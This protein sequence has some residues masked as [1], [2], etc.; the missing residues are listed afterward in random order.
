MKMLDAFSVPVGWMPIWR[1]DS[2]C[3]NFRFSKCGN[4]VVLLFFD[5]FV[6]VLLF[7]GLSTGCLDAE[8]VVF[9]A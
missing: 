2:G 3:S 6:V 8:E 1:P 9:D 7:I 5:R 4:F